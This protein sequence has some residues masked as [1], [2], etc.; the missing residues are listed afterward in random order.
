[1][2]VRRLNTDPAN[3]ELTF[4][5]AFGMTGRITRLLQLG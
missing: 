2:D 5:G 4:L 1:M 3:A